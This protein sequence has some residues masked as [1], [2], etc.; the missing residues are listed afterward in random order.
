MAVVKDFGGL[1]F[2]LLLGYLFM[3]FIKRRSAKEGRS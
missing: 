2:V 1:F 3:L